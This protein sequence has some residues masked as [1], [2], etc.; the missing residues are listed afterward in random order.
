MRVI[1]TMQSHFFPDLSCQSEEGGLQHIGADADARGQDQRERK[2]RRLQSAAAVVTR[3]TC[4]D[5]PLGC[6]EQRTHL[7]ERNLIVDHLG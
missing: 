1:V 3:G 4:D 7:L 5:S 6:N 2:S